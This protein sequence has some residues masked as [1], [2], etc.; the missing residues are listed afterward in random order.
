MWWPNKLLSCAPTPKE[1]AYTHVV[2]TLLRISFRNDTFAM[3]EKDCEKDTDSVL[4]KEVGDKDAST[5]P[6][7]REAPK[8][9]LDSGEER[10]RYRRQWWQM[11]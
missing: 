11:W 7:G 2:P 8:L 10:V 3:S 4:T 1:L 5:L 9:V 6:K